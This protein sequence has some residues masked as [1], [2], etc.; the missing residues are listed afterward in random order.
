[1][2]DYRI[3]NTPAQTLQIARINHRLAKNH[4]K[5]CTSRSRGEVSNLGD[6]YLL[7]RFANMIIETHVNL[8]EMER[9]MA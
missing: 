1:M 2:S 6:H 5:V 4:R 8:S 9:R 3:K 7:D